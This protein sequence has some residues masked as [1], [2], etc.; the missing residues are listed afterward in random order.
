MS[1]PLGSETYF[2]R[3]QASRRGYSKSFAKTK[4]P[5]VL[6]IHLIGRIS[7]W[8]T[9][10]KPSKETRPNTF[11]LAQRNKSGQRMLAK[12]HQIC[13]FKWQMDN[14]HGD[15]KRPRAPSLSLQ[16][17]NQELPKGTKPNVYQVAQR[18][19]SGLR[20]SKNTKFVTSSDRWTTSMETRRGQ[21]LRV[22]HFKW[23]IWKNNKPHH[24][25]LQTMRYFNLTKSLIQFSLSRRHL[26]QNDVKGLQKNPIEVFFKIIVSSLCHNDLTT[27]HQSKLRFCRV[28]VKILL[29]ST[30]VSLS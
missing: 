7:T 28:Q 21:G 5:S 24:E 26:T 13:H 23:Q 2:F 1:K 8:V 12:E 17:T 22:C 20:W 4:P 27:L 14:I 10:S 30:L 9:N 25:M 15:Q 16:V 29:P 11:L 18:K 19:K 3:V 6:P